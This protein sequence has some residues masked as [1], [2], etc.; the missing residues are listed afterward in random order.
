MCSNGHSTETG[1]LIRALRVHISLLAD[2]KGLVSRKK[3]DSHCFTLNGN[4]KKDVLML[5]AVIVD[6]FEHPLPKMRQLP[7]MLLH[8]IPIY[9]DASGH[10]AGPV[11]P[12]LGIFIASSH[13]FPSVAL[14]IEWEGWRMLRGR[15]DNCIGSAWSAS[16]FDCVHIG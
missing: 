4:T 9:T 3:R 14:A 5:A 7:V 2:N 11:S 15:Y 1:D 16:S 13:G 6:T 12:A 8:A 10:I